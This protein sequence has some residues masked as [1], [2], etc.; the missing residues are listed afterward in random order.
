MNHHVIGLALFL[1]VACPASTAWGIDSATAARLLHEDFFVFD[2]GVGRDEWTPEKQAATLAEL[3]YAGI[4]YSGVEDLAAR[5]AAFERDGVRIF[6]LYVPCYVD[7]EPSIGDELKRA[8]P[9]LE[10]TDIALWLTVQGKA[11]D[12]ARA[13]SVVRDVADRAAASGLRVALY[14]HA[15]FYVADMADALQIA[16]KVDREN[17]GVTFNL[18]HELKAGNAKR[19][20]ALLKKAMPKLF[21]VSINGAD[22]AGGWDRLIQPLGRGAFDL[23]GFLRKLMAWGY[24][25]PIGLQCYAVPGDQRA[26]LEHNI[27][28]WRQIVARLQAADE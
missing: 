14:P 8:I 25:G 26:N 10:G 20:D 3:G 22:H 1:L 11:D 9:Q 12:D 18:C 23:D 6:N 7:R 27:A 21:F 15:G 24:A 16:R 19:F 5:R 28:E 2:N 13:V 17:L 4:G